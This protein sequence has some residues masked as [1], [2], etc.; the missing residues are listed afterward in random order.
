MD[1]VSRWMCAAAIVLGMLLGGCA[2]VRPVV[3]SD[4][5]LRYG[6]VVADIRPVLH[7][8]DW[9]VTRGVH[10]TDDFVSFVTNAPLSH[11]AIYDA[12]N[13][14]VIEAEGIGVHATPLVEFIAKSQRLL[15]IRPVWASP[16]NCV[17]A[18][19]RARSWI[20]KGYNL[21]G[22]VGLN[23]A[24]AYYCTQL[25]IEAYRPEV[26]MVPSGGAQ[27]GGDH[28]NPFPMVIQPGQMYH[29]GR[30]MYDSG[31]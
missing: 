26:Q 27:D 10:A 13:D 7:H 21:T 20:G 9:L 31:P 8:G 15:V 11:A 12:F 16:E 17:R 28:L 23:M 2:A 30:I 24:D 29:W 6:V 19:E 1:S 22:L 18:V 14:E 25:V 4:A 5:A 3:G